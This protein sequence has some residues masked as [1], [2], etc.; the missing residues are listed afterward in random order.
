MLNIIRHLENSNQNH[1]T[2]TRMAIALRRRKFVSIVENKEKL[3][4][5]H[6]SDGN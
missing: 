5:S 1:I 3:E 4:L 6:I 2:A